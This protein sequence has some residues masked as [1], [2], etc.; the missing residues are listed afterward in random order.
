MR[1]ELKAITASAPSRL[2]QPGHPPAQARSR[3]S[4]RRGIL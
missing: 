4:L 1:S 3:R 2:G